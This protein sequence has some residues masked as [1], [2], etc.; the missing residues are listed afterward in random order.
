MKQAIIEADK[1]VNTAL[2]NAGFTGETTYKKIEQILSD[3][4]GWIRGAG[5][6]AAEYREK[7][8]YDPDFKIYASDVKQA[9]QNYEI[10]LKEL[11][12]IDPNT[13]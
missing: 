10:V 9:I 4:L 7:M 2:E 1:L 13:F 6:K 11:N 8:H 3:E 12:V 5:Y